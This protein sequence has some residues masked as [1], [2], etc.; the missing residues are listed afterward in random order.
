MYKISELCYGID[1]ALSLDLLPFLVMSVTETSSLPKNQRVV[2]VTGA[3]GFIGFHISIAMVMEWRAS[4]VGVDS[5]S[6][7]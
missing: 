1:M 4:V 7:Y 2:L 3:A 5:F 6:P